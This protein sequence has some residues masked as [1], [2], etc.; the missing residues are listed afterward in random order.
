MA[1]T[2]MVKQLAHRTSNAGKVVHLHLDH[3]NSIEVRDLAL[4][5]T[6]GMVLK[7]LA[8]H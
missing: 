5:Y 8:D 2:V 7:Q 4:P 1:Y 3:K 6:K